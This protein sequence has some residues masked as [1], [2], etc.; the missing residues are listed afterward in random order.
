MF[1]ALTSCSSGMWLMIF[2]GFLFLSLLVLAIV[3]LAKYVFRDA[4][5]D[6]RSET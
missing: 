2:V 4:L 1:D 3:A 5:R 6:R